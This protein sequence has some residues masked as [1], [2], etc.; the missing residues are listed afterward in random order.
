M[1]ALDQT[2]TRRRRPGQ[3]REETDAQA[4]RLQQQAD[5]DVREQLRQQEQERR[6]AELAAQVA[7]AKGRPA[8]IFAHDVYPEPT[9][10]QQTTE[11]APPPARPSNIPRHVWDQIMSL[12]GS[13]NV[14][15]DPTEFEALVR[16]HYPEGR[17]GNYTPLVLIEAQIRQGHGP[18]LQTVAQQINYLIS[19][20]WSWD[21]LEPARPHLIRCLQAIHGHYGQLDGV[22]WS[23]LYRRP[24]VMPWPPP[25][26]EEELAEIEEQR[27]RD[28]IEAVRQQIEEADQAAQQHRQQAEEAAARRAQLAQKLAELENEPTT[29]D[30]QKELQP[31]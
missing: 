6:D 19:V 25:P 23:D 5:E 24:R 27:H 20:V 9:E 30:N 11:P 17:T 22:H 4:A 29:T 7:A 8:P 21:G 14:A 16:T 15:P 12:I 2:T 10:E 18:W 26:T 1:P 3:P 31:A 13:R 28:R